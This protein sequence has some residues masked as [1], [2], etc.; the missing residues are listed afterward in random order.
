MANT[1]KNASLT[2]VTNGSAENLYT[3]PVGTTTVV[4]G[5]AIANKSPNTV[6]VTLSFSDDSA[7]TFTDLISGVQIPGNTT[8]EVLAGQKYILEP[9]DSLL[10]A[11]DTADS[12]DITMGVMEIS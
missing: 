12:I 9:S 3:T 6:S 1:F 10:A 7:G 8:L 11:A 4:L 2:D 5:A